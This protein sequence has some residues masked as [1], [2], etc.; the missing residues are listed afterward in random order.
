VQD[1]KEGVDR[2]AVRVDEDVALLDDGFRADV[3]QLRDEALV[4]R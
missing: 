1:E 4:Q 3:E 2:L